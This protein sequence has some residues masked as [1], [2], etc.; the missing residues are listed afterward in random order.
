MKDRFFWRYKTYFQ[1]CP[2]QVIKSSLYALRI[3]DDLGV[4]SNVMLCT[5]YSNNNR[6]TL[7]KFK[8]RFIEQI[9]ALL[10]KVLSKDGVEINIGSFCVQKQNRWYINKR[11]QYESVSVL[12]KVT[13]YAYIHVHWIE[14]S[15]KSKVVFMLKRFHYEKVFRLLL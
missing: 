13:L 11:F 7:L 2:K 4:Y 14:T 15:R 3:C 8:R 5:Q 9:F 1:F 6:K 12:F 10:H